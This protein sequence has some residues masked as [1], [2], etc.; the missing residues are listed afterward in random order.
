MNK[1]EQINKL[2]E[3]ALSSVDDAQR[4]A[5]KPYLLTR[6]NARMNKS[7]E[8]VW[9]KA[10]WFITRPAVAFGGLCLIVL[11]NAMVIFYS[12]TTTSVANA[13]MVVQ[14]TSDEFSYTGATI[15]DTDNTAP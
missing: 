5:P 1:Q 12:K 8:S 3:E 14:N 7:A 9:E 2:I 11:I 10:A 4:A 13:D 15:Y 6:I